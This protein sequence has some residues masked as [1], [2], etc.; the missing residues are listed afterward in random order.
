MPLKIIK[1]LP[2]LPN[3]CFQNDDI[4]KSKKI[5]RLTSTHST[6]VECYKFYSWIHFLIGL[7]FQCFLSYFNSLCFFL[8][9]MKQYYQY[10]V[11]HSSSGILQK[12]MGF[13]TD[14]DMN[15]CRNRRAGRFLLHL[16][17]VSIKVFCQLECTPTKLLT[18]KSQITIV[19][20]SIKSKDQPRMSRIKSSNV[21]K[22]A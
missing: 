4:K 6:T 13:D 8:L 21:R 12:E 14:S 17:R 2:F 22:V 11:S 3:F 19:R 10:H 7:P 1:Q 16:S 5:K 15:R 18:H 20:Q 9:D